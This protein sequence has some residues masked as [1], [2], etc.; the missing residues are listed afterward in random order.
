MLSA[1]THN[2]SL[3]GEPTTRPTAE[4]FKNDH[5]RRAPNISAAYFR[6]IKSDSVSLNLNVLFADPT[7][8]LSAAIQRNL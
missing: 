2:K 7:I 6:R 3:P 5:H 1:Q 8:A 4:P